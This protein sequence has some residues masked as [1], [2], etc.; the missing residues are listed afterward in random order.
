MVSTIEDIERIIEQAVSPNF[1]GRLLDKGL[2]RSM[3]WDKG[4]LLE[5]SPSALQGDGLSYNLLS[6]SFSLLSLAIR[7]VELGGNSDFAR[8]AFE[9]SA[10]A[11]THLLHNGDENNPNNGFYR[12]LAA[13]SYHLG[14]FSA[15]AFSLLSDDEKNKNLS[16]TEELLSLLIL[17]KFSVLE[18]KVLEWKK[19]KCAADE[20]LAEQLTDSIDIEIFDLAITDNYYSAIFE[21]L[22]ALEIGNAELFKNSIIR[23]EK[24]LSACVKLNMVPQWWVLRITKH[25]LHDLWESSFHRVLPTVSGD[26]V[27]GEDWEELRKIFIASLFKR[28]KA[29]IELW[30]SQMEGAKRSIDDNDDLVVSLPTS[31]GKTRI[32]ELCILRCLSIGKR[33]LFITP[34]RALSAQTEATLRKTF[35]PLGKK[36]STLYGSVGASDFDRNAIKTNDIVV[37]T[38]EKLDFALRNDSTLIDDVGLIV[39]DEGHMIGLKEREINYEVQIQRLLKRK[40]AD[41][42]RIVCL[43]AILPNTEELKD[44]VAWLRKNKEGKAIELDWRPTDLRYGTISWKGDSATMKFA[45]DKEESYIHNYITPFIPPKNGRTNFF[46]IDKKE[47]T[48]ATAWKLYKLN[49]HTVLVY[50]SERR[51]VNSFAKHIIKLC[52][53]EAIE[54]VLSEESKERI[55]LA[56]ALGNEWLGEKHPIV[57]CLKIGVAI[58]HA[59]LPTPFRKEME[60]LL[61]EGFFKI[62]ISSPTLAQGLNLSATALIFYSLSRNREIIPY[63]EFAN[64]VGRAG[65]AFDD[66]YGLVLYPIFKNRNKNEREWTNLIE[67]ENDKKMTSGLALLV[68]KLLKQML[69]SIGSVEN[70]SDKIIEYITNNDAAWSFP[71]SI[72][73]TEKEWNKN[74]AT[75]DTALLS[76]LGEEDILKENIPDALHTAL[77]HSLWKRN[78][79]RSDK[80]YR[81]L[82]DYAL[83]QRAKYIWSKTKPLQRKGYFRAGVGLNT[84]EYL[85]RISKK[86]N[87]FLIDA[88]SYI[89]SGNQSKAIEAIT[90][91]AALLFEVDPF[92]P[93][94]FP[95]NW[96]EILNIWLRGET[97]NSIDNI[98]VALN[99]IEDA[100]VYRLCWGVE[101]VKVRA[102]A[103]KDSISE[104]MTIDDI[105]ILFVASAIENGTLNVSA[106]LLMQ[107]GF[108]SRRGAIYAANYTNASFDN[109]KSLKAWLKADAVSSLNIEENWSIPED[110]KLWQ[111]FLEEYN[112]SSDKAWTSEKLTMLAEWDDGYT[113]V[114]GVNVKLYKDGDKIEILASNGERIG[115][116]QG[117]HR[118][119]E[120]GIYEVKIINEAGLLDVTYWGTNEA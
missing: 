42:R 118:F 75:L 65:R 43:S 70:N 88:D 116:I 23:V 81:E 68:Q 46:P 98:D 60:K 91:L 85:D 45:M 59:R 35:S 97:I 80:S 4:A 119:R 110:Y 29:E 14:R 38:P 30:P 66:T 92:T 101:A 17:R 24:S 52:K 13:S 109:A 41:Q 9:K 55:N 78:L 51:Y 31:A 95:C 15:K 102:Q 10:A 76:M 39:L 79:S 16:E 47:L 103:N 71:S 19:S 54:E 105:E 37:G 112:A 56:L 100:L 36:V 2:A 27:R 86:A 8:L 104:D 11:I 32:A 106:A 49:N 69:D 84:G 53:Q 1:R 96:E 82:F 28:E 117:E 61:K 114:E 111:N 108:H 44:F 93:E 62:I 21:F 34:L 57:E 5:G 26:G 89:S 94:D 72:V 25:L 67:G 115:S 18:S 90:A 22:F 113:P 73:E 6:Y 50:C 3:M 99:F 48:L 63:S 83:E 77:E 58:H 64:V 107:A 120:G 20:T 87:R 40:D 33:V 74:I 12:I 7:L